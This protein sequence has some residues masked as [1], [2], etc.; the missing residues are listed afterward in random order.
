MSAVTETD[1]R[2]YADRPESGDDLWLDNV[3]TGWRKTITGYSQS[4]PH[5]GMETNC[6]Q[7][8]PGGDFA[9]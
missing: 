8:V 9:L 6:L 3:T 5:S 1:V 2:H 7:V 4:H